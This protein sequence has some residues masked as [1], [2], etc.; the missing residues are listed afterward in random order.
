LDQV[1]EEHAVRGV[2]PSQGDD[3]QE[4]GLKQLFLGPTAVP[5]DPLEIRPLI[6]GQA[7]AFK[8]FLSEQADFDPLGELNFLLGV[9]QRSLTDLVQINPKQNG[10]PQTIIAITEDSEDR[11]IAI[12]PRSLDID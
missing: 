2:P 12:L 8:F 1:Q 10:V 3:K 6:L 5:G 4:V 7:L 11:L 9:E